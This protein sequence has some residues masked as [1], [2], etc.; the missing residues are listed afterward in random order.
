MALSRRGSAVLAHG[1]TDLKRYLPISLFATSIVAGLPLWV[2]LGPGLDHGLVATLL[3]IALSFALADLGARAWK[4]WPGSRDVVFNDLMLW[5]FC[6]RI[7]TQRRLIQRIELL[8]FSADDP[9]GLTR[10]ERTD[11]IKKLAIALEAGDPYT[12]G[13]SQRVARHAYQVAK[14]MRLSREEIEKIRLSG[15][16]HDVGKLRIPRSIITKPDK[17]TDAEFDVIKRHTVDGAA[18]VEELGDPDLVDMV[19]H[20]H[21]RLD[22]SGYPDKLRGDDISIGARILAVA[23]TF[24]A[25]SSLRPYRAAQKHQVALDLLQEEAA[26]GRLDPAVVDAFISYYSGARALRWWTFLSVGPANLYRFSTSFGGTVGA[27]GIA[28]AAIIGITAVAL[29]PWPGFGV[30]EPSRDQDQRVAATESRVGEQGSRGPTRSSGPRFAGGG[31][32]PGAA[33]AGEGPQ[34]GAGGKADDEKK[35]RRSGSGKGSKPRDKSSKA[36]N[37]G[38]KSDGRSE[39]GGGPSAAVAETVEGNTADTPAAAAENVRG[40]GPARDPGNRTVPL[41]EVASD[42]GKNK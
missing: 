12:H 13:H 17:L 28:N 11:L 29:T 41:P 6:R 5:G 21:E 8:R 19:R 14:T 9:D 26:A 20:H 34:R 35:N 38:S 10:E 36:G 18:M 2:L 3:S 42:L 37:K 25:V 4:R 31:G 24:D 7:V 23:D 33:A 32:A 16:I 22:G 1:P 15:V 40:A 39:R 27:A 30:D